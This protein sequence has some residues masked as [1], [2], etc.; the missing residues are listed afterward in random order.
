MK[1]EYCCNNFPFAVLGQP[2]DEWIRIPH[3]SCE[4]FDSKHF[5]EDL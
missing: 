1:T 4:T 5:L 2:G 3:E